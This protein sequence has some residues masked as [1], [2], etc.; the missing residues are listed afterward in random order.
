MVAHVC[1]ELSWGRGTGVQCAVP[2]HVVR[3]ITIGVEIGGAEESARVVAHQ[4]RS[5]RPLA[6][7]FAIGTSLGDHDSGQAEGKRPIR[8]PAGRAATDQLS[9]PSRPGGDR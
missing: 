2:R 3:G 7:K 9:S 6:H 5:V 4:E 1:V 8:R